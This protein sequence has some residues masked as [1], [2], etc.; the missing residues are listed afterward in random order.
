MGSASI[1]NEEFKELIDMRSQ[2][3][4][5]LVN[6]LRRCQPGDNILTRPLLGQLLSQSRQLEE[7]LDAYDASNNC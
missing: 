4:L 6:Y 2:P 7:L 3:L 1:T 5:G